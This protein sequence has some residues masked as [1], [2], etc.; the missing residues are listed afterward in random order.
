MDTTALAAQSAPSVLWGLKLY[1]LLTLV[2]IIIGPIS[3]VAISLCFEQRKRTREARTQILR[4]LIN[5]R[6]MPSDP[7][8]SIAIN[9]IPVEFN[10]HK[11]VMQAWRN[12][13]E[14][15]RYDP[16]PENAAAH[17]QKLNANQVSMIYQIMKSLNLGLSESDIQTEGYLARGFTNRDNLYLDSLRAMRE[18]ADAATRSAAVT[19]R[20]LASSDASTRGV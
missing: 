7:A 14:S 12:Y 5:T 20:L 9:L 16:S 19:E 11:A 13:I 4:M 10:G 15:V 8:Y 6:G 3:A 2:G 1:E 18:I 17:D